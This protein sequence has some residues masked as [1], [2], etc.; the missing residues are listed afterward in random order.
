MPHERRGLED[1]RALVAELCPADFFEAS[2]GLCEDCGNVSDLGRKCRPC[3]A[4]WK[5][6]LWQDIPRRARELRDV[7]AE[8][9]KAPPHIAKA[10]ANGDPANLQGVFAMLYVRVNAVLTGPFKAEMEGKLSAIRVAASAETKS[11]GRNSAAA[12]VE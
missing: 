5:R 2:E 12:E 6:L 1:V 7:N 10:I 3:Y 11:R 8:L 4:V 9:N